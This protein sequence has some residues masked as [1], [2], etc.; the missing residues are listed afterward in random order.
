M[1]RFELKKIFGTL[2]GRIALLLYLILLILSCWMSATGAL[3]MGIATR[4]ENGREVTG[5]AAVRRIRAARKEW[6]GVL[7]TERIAAVI[8]ELNRI[9]ASPEANSDVILERDIAYSWQDGVRPIRDMLIDAYNDSLDVY[10]Y[11][12]YF[13]PDHLSPADAPYFYTNRMK[14]LEAYLETGNGKDRFTE[15]EKQWLTQHY[16]Q[17][18]TPIVYQYN[19]GWQQLLENTMLF[20]AYGALILGFLVTGIFTK[21]FRWKGDAVYFSTVY[22]PN[23]AIAAKIKAGVL[24]VTA[25]YFG[26]MLVYTLFTL[27]YFGF[28]GAGTAIQLIPHYWETPYNWTCGQTYLVM[29]ACGYLGN[30]FVAFLTM[31]V[32]AKTRS[33]SLSVTVSFFAI[34]MGWMLE[35]TGIKALEN[36]TLLPDRLLIAFQ[37]LSKFEVCDLGFG[38]AGM[39]PV[40]A[41]FYGALTVLLIPMMYRAFRAAPRQ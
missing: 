18:D 15:N 22:G 19:L 17:W 10:E 9:A 11:N 27:C 25:L 30:L 5:P 13:I 2:G 29:V 14:L 7:D 37:Y 8:R 3:D 4:D 24:T 32:S 21:E 41:G 35:M 6:E 1:V 36:I 34:L 12:D 40:A 16:A 33:P 39:L 28:E 38:G 26:A 23:K 31:Y 20:S